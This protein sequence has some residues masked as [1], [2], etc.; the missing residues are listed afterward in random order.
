MK[1]E[2]V[3]F[4]VQSVFGLDFYKLNDVDYT[5]KIKDACV[6]N[7]YL[8]LA[9]VIPYKEKTSK[10]EKYSLKKSVKDYL[11]TTPLCE[12]VLSIIDEVYKIANKK[13]GNL[14]EEE[15]TFGMTQK[16]VNMTLK[17][18]WLFDICPIPT[19]NLH[20]P[21]DSY[22]IDALWKESTTIELPIKDS[23]YKREK[24]YTK[25]S[26]YVIAWSNW[27]KNHYNKMWQSYSK[28][29]SENLM[30]NYKS[31]IEWENQKWIDVSNER[32]NN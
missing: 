11:V 30:N 5:C 23:K 20:I 17:Y 3:P 29:Y 9:R 31:P 21:I 24:N 22:I 32:K 13:Y 1:E 12:N 25:P 26:E 4:M 8:D 16:W 28:Y 2:M 18:F 7:A 15:F 27:D 10:D 14:F 6:G 19:S